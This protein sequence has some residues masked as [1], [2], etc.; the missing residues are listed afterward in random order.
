MREPRGGWVG[1]VTPPLA[2]PPSLPAP[3]EGA[4]R[5]AV[6][7]LFTR[8]ACR[9][10]DILPLPYP[11][12][13]RGP[14]ELLQPGAMERKEHPGG[15]P[16]IPGHNDGPC[17][18][19][20]GAVVQRTQVLLLAGEPWGSD[21]GQSVLSSFAQHVLPPTVDTSSNCR[22]AP[23]A[24]CQGESSATPQL[25]LSPTGPSGQLIFFLCRASSLRE[26]PERLREVLRGV[27]EQSRGAPAA[28]V[29]V[30]VQ[31]RPEE[32]VEARRSLEELLRD[33]F[34]AGSA[35][36]IEVHTAVFA[37]GRP[38]G[39]LELYRVKDHTAGE[40]R[41]G[42]GRGTERTHARLGRRQGRLASWQEEPAR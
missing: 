5:P 38:Q 28:L 26:R 19:E 36:P 10:C 16:Q 13:K 39:A 25:P 18:G 6:T 12:G 27:R 41:G 2:F 24:A 17:E 42:G 9:D 34:Q 31:P 14:G 22:Q 4:R 30:I 20:A 21:D 23:R 7:Q 37:P 3:K 1:G 40:G 33:T 32:E 8:E 11:A 15:G 29:G 35:A